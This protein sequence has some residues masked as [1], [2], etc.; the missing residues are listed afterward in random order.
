M[1]KQLYEQV[2]QL[3]SARD[4]VRSYCF[5]GIWTGPEGINRMYVYFPIPKTVKSVWVFWK[6]VHT[7]TQW[8]RV[9]VALRPY[10]GTIRD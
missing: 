9:R 6:H 5:G 7:G 4:D 2:V 1:D 10:H 3:F 8:T